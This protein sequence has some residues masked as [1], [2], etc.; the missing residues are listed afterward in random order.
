MRGPTTDGYEDDLISI[1]PFSWSDDADRASLPNFLFTPSGF[2]ME[3]YKYSWRGAEMSENLSLGEIRRIWRLC[4][5]HLLTGRSFN[6]GDTDSF[7]RLRPYMVDVPEDLRER[8]VS[9]CEMV[10]DIEL[11]RFE[12]RSTGYHGSYY[13]IGRTEELDGRALEMIG[14]LRELLEGRHRS[15][16]SIQVKVIR[17]E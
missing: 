2:N 17:F 14:E 11:H 12:N 1:R 5:D 13:E 9:V 10:K 8:V 6:A 4:V 3:W 15:P 7:F 16:S